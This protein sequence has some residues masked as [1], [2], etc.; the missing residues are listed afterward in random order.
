M[1]CS[2]AVR[3]LRAEPNVTCPGDPA[4]LTW[5]AS[6]AGGLTDTPSTAPTLWVPNSGSMKVYPQVKTTYRLEVHNWFGSDARE[7]DI[8]VRSSFPTKTLGRSLSDPSA[9]CAQDQVSVEVDLT[10]T[11]WS[12]DLVVQSV[13]LPDGVHRTLHVEHDS[14]ELT[15]DDQNRESNALTGSPVLGRWILST[16][17]TEGEVCSSPT[18]PPSLGLAVE[19]SCAR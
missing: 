19:L 13:R 1:A 14:K 18:I 6:M 12:N 9:R 17:L 4:S 7:V 3:A 2:P 8:D 15:L 16:P 5:D 10:T 11:G